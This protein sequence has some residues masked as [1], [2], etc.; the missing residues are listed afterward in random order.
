MR[1]VYCRHYT[2]CGDREEYTLDNIDGK[3][4]TYDY[5]FVN[6][7]KVYSWRTCSLLQL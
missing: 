7:A 5:F 4:F 3:Q 6:S 1:G 2:T